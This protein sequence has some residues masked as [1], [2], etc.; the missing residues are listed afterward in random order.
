LNN[1][2]TYATPPGPDL[3]EITSVFE[4]LSETFE[5]GRRLVY[6][7]QND[8][9]AIDSQLEHLQAELDRHHL[10]EFQALVPALRSVSSDRRLGA[11]TRARAEKLLELAQRWH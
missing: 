8:R 2:F 1:Q 10:R 9:N 4:E 5:S 6:L 3:D 7:Q 11:E